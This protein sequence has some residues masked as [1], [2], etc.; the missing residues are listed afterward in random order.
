MPRGRNPKPTAL[1]VLHG[2]PGKRKLPA[3]EPK[4]PVVLDVPAAPEWMPEVA[5]EKWR[6]IAGWLVST[7]IL[8]ESD[9]HNL[10][11]FCCAYA[12]FREAEADIAKNGIVL[13]DD[14]YAPA[15]NPAVTVVNEA[16]RQLQCHG[17]SLGLDPASRARMGAGKKDD[18]ADDDE[19]FMRAR[20]RR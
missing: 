12:R 9:L 16:L 18:D 5:R 3:D 7:R 8:T 11:A 2:N 13:R 6:D 1:K 17:S 15:K 14:E 19:S 4:P 20:E 10:E